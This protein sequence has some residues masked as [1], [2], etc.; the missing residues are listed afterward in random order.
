MGTVTGS[1]HLRIWLVETVFIN[2]GRI[3]FNSEGPSLHRGSMV[4]RTNGATLYANWR[5]RVAN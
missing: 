3:E 4:R 2:K 5:P 1:G